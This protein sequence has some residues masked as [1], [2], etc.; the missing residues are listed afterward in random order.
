M[1]TCI[2]ISDLLFK[3]FKVDISNSLVLE[4]EDKIPSD[5][6]SGLDFPEIAGV[7]FPFQE[8]PFG[9]RDPCEVAII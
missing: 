8:L 4:A 2:Y 7:P 1:G 6:I 9:V 3:E 5:N